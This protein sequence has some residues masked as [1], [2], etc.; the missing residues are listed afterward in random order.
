VAALDE[1]LSHAGRG[2]RRLLIAGAAAV[3][4]PAAFAHTG[5]GPVLPRVRAP[6]L[7]LTLHDG[8]KSSLQGLLQGRVCAV[9]LMFT[10]CSAT[11]PL[12]GAVFAALQQQLSGPAAALPG[13]RLLSISIDPLAD[14]A[15]ALAA[16]RRRFG[17]DER[18]IAAVPPLRHADV[19]LDFVDGPARAAGPDR[20]AA[21]TV[22]FDARGRL[23]YRMAPLAAA[24]DIARVLREL[25]RLPLPPD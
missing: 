13:A 19:M 12:Q 15:R 2:R 6:N 24:A 5:L 1:S 16:W 9:Q 10:G 20:H 8:S 7:E 4:A 3:A 18:W 23:A 17:A 11:C 21:Q 14:D 22:L 25:D